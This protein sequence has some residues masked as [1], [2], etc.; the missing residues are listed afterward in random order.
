MSRMPSSDLPVDTPRGVSVSFARTDA[1]HRDPSRPVV[2]QAPI[3]IDPGRLRGGASMFVLGARHDAVNGYPI[4]AAK[5]QRPPLRD[6]TLARDRL[7]DWLGKKVHHRVVL[8]VAEAGYGKTTL[9]ADF[10]RRTRMR[11]LWYRLDEDD[12]DWISLLNHLVAAGREHDPGFAPTTASMLADSG[13][14]GPSRDAVIRAFVRELPSIAEHGAAL[15]LDDFHLV[16]DAPDVKLVAREIVS[17]AP[18]RLTIVFSSRRQPTIPIA[19]LR[20]IG[21][22]A[23]L[24]TDDLRFDAGEAGQL[25]AEMYGRPLE[26]DVLRDLT[27]RT[28]GWAASLQLVRTAIRDRT[29]TEIRSFVRTLTGVDNELYDYLAEEVIGELPDDLQRFLMRTSILQ[30][31]D[32]ELA[33]IVTD[34]EPTRIRALMSDA[35]RLGLL[36]R[37]GQVTR[38]AFR[39]HP[40]VRDF[41]EERLRR[42]VGDDEIGAIHRSTARRTEAID[43]RLAGHHYAA[44]DDE[45]DVRRVISG[46]LPRIMGN[47]QYALA[48]TYL[49][50]LQSDAKP[51]L[52]TAIIDSRMAFRRGDAAL[53]VQ[54]ARDAVAIE[55]DAELS[56]ANLASVLL[57]VVD[58]ARSADA[59]K[60]LQLS[61]K[62]V[63]LAAI[64]SAALAGLRTATDGNLVEA[65][66]QFRRLA[67]RQLAR[68]HPQ[69]GRVPDDGVTARTG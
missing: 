54:R 9:L 55:P 42:E 34:L 17:H 47:G 16:D 6:E 50:R 30:I 26:S 67:S 23:E 2:D 37:R 45:A 68:G 22:V 25:F 58:P 36:S 69:Y 27:S 15:I 64:A 31:V 32:P 20:A 61:A 62:D 10:S 19:R 44:A 40:L 48:D 46:A 7:L 49:E 14:P 29:P 4:Q 59:F 18:E 13:V 35:E 51:D 56:M 53:A 11:T 39:S 5:V 52:S 63:D 60:R 21:E 1:P 24:R 3:P 28:E 65:A 43:W 57:S 66:Q 33:A 8:V 12:R 38:D 41:L